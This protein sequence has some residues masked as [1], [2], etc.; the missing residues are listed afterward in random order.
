[1]ILKQ[2]YLT[3]FVCFFCCVS[4]TNADSRSECNSEKPSSKIEVLLKNFTG[5]EQTL[6][7]IGYMGKNKKVIDSIFIDGFKDSKFSFKSRTTLEPGIYELHIN[8]QAFPFAKGKEAQS[9][10]IDLLN[11]SVKGNR[12]QASNLAFLECVKA[13]KK[14]NIDQQVLK[15]I[16]DQKVKESEVRGVPLNETLIDLLAEQ[17]Q[18]YF[19]WI[20]EILH[21]QKEYQNTYA[22]DILSPMY[23]AEVD[24][25]KISTIKLPIRE[26][27]AYIDENYF[28]EWDFSNSSILN[29]PLFD[30]KIEQYLFA[31]AKKIKSDSTAFETAVDYI[32]KY[33]YPN[34]VV[35]QHTVQLLTDVF[36]QRGPE[37]AVNYLYENYI[38]SCS[39]IEGSISRVNIKRI[40]SMRRFKLGT[41][42]PNFQI[43]ELSGKTL[44]FFSEIEAK[45]GI[46]LLLFWSSSCTHC[47][48]EIPRIYALFEEF[49]NKG[50]NVVA[51]SMD[52]NKNDTKYFL[53]E[54]LLK[55]ISLNSFEE[56]DTGWI[57]SCDEKGFSSE[58]V[59]KYF[60]YGTPMGFLID[61]NK[62]LIGKYIESTK[63]L[64]AVSTT[65]NE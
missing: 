41:T 39:D 33:A 61:K 49:K 27:N 38:N 45:R 14:V 13:K 22:A 46:T 59:E 56:G 31:Q 2:L 9:L 63:I 20:D 21:F 10:E 16:F 50:L 18:L 34:E 8:N 6:Y 64:K 29:N 23:F 17:E 3:V 43:D 54:H 57:N 4:P 37:E 48:E 11:K 12:E 28:K 44:D 42:V 47:Q 52:K 19:Q 40:E 65:L 15:E 53:K 1:M 36:L 5:S 26:I 24:K 7:L 51:I 60:V 32:M 58:T 35:R 25:R 62:T 55:A 30:M